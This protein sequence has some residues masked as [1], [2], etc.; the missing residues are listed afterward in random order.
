MKYLLLT[1]L[2]ILTGCTKGVPAD[3]LV[4]PQRIKYGVNSQTPYTGNSVEYYENGQHKE[5]VNHK[6][7]EA[8]GLVG[9]L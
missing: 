2:L 1:L 4:S 9:D 7:G 6:D 3:K 8:D 5:K